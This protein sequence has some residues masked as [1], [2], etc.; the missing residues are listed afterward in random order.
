[1]RKWEDWIL[2]LSFFCLHY[3]RITCW[4]IRQRPLYWDESVLLFYCHPQWEFLRRPCW[5]LVQHCYIPI[6]HTLLVRL[7]NRCW[8]P[9]YRIVN[10]FVLVQRLNALWCL[11]L[12]VIDAHFGGACIYCMVVLP[13]SYMVNK[14]FIYLWPIEYW[15]YI[16]Y[17]CQPVGLLWNFFG[18]LP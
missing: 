7:W 17:Q 10:S 13:N 16:C 12:R 4:I 9:R 5:L 15:P 18:I 3:L 6:S 8:R 1:M 2:L 11:L 14:K